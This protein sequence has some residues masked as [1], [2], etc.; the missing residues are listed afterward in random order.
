MPEVGAA[1][2]ASRRRWLRADIPE[3]GRTQGLRDHDQKVRRTKATPLQ[4][5]GLGRRQRVRA[6]GPE[7]REAVP[8][9][10]LP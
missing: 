6:T 4:G 9:P 5:E 10:A 1:W 7:S 8:A 2:E 3:S